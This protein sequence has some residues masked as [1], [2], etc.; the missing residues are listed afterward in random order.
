M[1]REVD[2]ESHRV[3]RK[4][5]LRLDQKIKTRVDGEAAAETRTPWASRSSIDVSWLCADARR[6]LI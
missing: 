5:N 3:N 1:T 4:V 6:G 2:R